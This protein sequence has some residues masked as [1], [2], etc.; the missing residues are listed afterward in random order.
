MTYFLSEIAR[1]IG[2]HTGRRA[3]CR[4]RCPTLRHRAE[5]K[6]RGPFMK[7][8]GPTDRNRLSSVTA[9]FALHTGEGYSI[10]AQPPMWDPLSRRVS[11]IHPPACHRVECCHRHRNAESYRPLRLRQIRHERVNTIRGR[12]PEPAWCRPR[13]CVQQDP[14]PPLRRRLSLRLI[15]SVACDGFVIH[16]E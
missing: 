12:L 14:Q 7:S 5:R 3:Q 15:A 1:S 11:P 6:K 4:T 16:R 10:V 2:C 13:N 9:A 8:K